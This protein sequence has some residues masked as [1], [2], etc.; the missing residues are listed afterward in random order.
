[1][2]RRTLIAGLS[3]A[4][5]VVG[6]TSSL[7]LAQAPVAAPTS[8]DLA[9][10][11]QRTLMVGSLAKQT[12]ELALRQASHPEVKQFASFETAEQT[13][14]A[15]VLTDTQSPVPAPLDATHAA[16]LQQVQAAAGPTFDGVYVQGQ[17][18]CHQELLEIQNAFLQAQPS[19]ATDPVHIAML[20]RT[21]I[22][23]QDLANRIVRA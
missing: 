6:A 12:S 4:A 18:Q 11:R 16:M 8:L 3:G 10:Y 5:V 19:I 2:N 21:V 17:I 14:L 13:T 9:Q 1:M 7:S 20:A 22:Q 23:M 15:Q